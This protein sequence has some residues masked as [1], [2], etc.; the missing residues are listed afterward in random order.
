MKSARLNAELIIF[1]LYIG[2]HWPVQ[3]QETADL[4]I[5]MGPQVSEFNHPNYPT[6]M[7]RNGAEGWVVVNY[8]VDTNGNAF[9]PTIVGSSGARMFEKAAIRAIT[10][11]KFKP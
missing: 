7:A 4:D 3:A 1:A 5:F 11:T 9:E 8:M 6:E 10:K 2:S